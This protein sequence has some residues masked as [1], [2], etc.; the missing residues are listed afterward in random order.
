MM[1]PPTPGENVFFAVVAAVVILLYFLPDII[2]GILV[3]RSLVRF[4][5]D[6]PS[7]PR[8]VGVAKIAIQFLLLGGAVVLFFYQLLNSDTYLVKWKV[9]GAIVVL[10]IV[11]GWVGYRRPV[12]FLD[13]EY[14]KEE[15]PPEQ[16]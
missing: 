15:N 8:F 16:T 2:S 3:I 14:D 5:Y 10:I 6:A 7:K 1:G 11:S 9:C 4:S 13:R 12:S